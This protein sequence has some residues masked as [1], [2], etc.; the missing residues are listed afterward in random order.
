MRSISVRPLQT[1]LSEVYKLLLKKSGQLENKSS[2]NRI[3]FLLPCI[4][5]SLLHRKAIFNC[6]RGREAAGH[7]RVLGGRFTSLQ[8]T[9]KSPNGVDAAHRE[10]IPTLRG[11]YRVNV[12][13]WLLDGN[14]QHPITASISIV[15]QKEVQLRFGK[16][17]GQLDLQR[18]NLYYV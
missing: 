14:R 15:S 12:G 16:K 10:V 11:L 5:F 7:G 1:H 3:Q 13:N 17:V 8:A 9:H 2:K 18:N 6:S 4:I